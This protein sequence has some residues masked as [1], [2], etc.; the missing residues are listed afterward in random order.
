MMEYK[1]MEENGTTKVTVW[2]VGKLKP[3]KTN[4]NSEPRFFF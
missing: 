2:F 1:I 4:K 3:F